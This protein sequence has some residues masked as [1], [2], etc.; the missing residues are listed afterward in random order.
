MHLKIKLL[1]LIE[2]WVRNKNGTNLKFMRL[3][4][5]IF[6]WTIHIFKLIYR[7]EVK[8]LKY[9]K[10]EIPV[11]L[12]ICLNNHHKSILHTMIKTDYPNQILQLISA[13]HSVTLFT[14]KYKSNQ[15]TVSRPY[16]T[17]SVKKAWVGSLEWGRATV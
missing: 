5:R 11:L 13:G 14:T 15:L 10:A 3:K 6:F 16:G 4:E 2:Y 12:G 9:S 1:K 8:I 17:V 7:Q